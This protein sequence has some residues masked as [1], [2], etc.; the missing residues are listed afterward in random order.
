MLQRNEELREISLFAWQSV[1]LANSTRR[2]IV[3]RV[4]RGVIPFHP[5][6]R[7][8]SLSADIFGERYRLGPEGQ[9][10]EREGTLG[11]QLRRAGRL[12][13]EIG[14]RGSNRRRRPDG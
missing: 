4:K 2:S 14:R 3:A 7:H 10:G 12:R 11:R 8:F 5:T 1:D 9:Y 6:S 13:Q